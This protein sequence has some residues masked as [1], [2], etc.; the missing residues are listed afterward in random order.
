MNLVRN[1][2]RNRAT[3]RARC[4]Q[5]G[6][7]RWFAYALTFLTLFGCGGSDM[8]CQDFNTDPPVKPIQ[9]NGIYFT[10]ANSFGSPTVTQGEILNVPITVDNTYSTAGENSVITP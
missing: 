3:E 10:N 2:N 6:G 5:N 4:G 1:S 9:T 7:T 8:G